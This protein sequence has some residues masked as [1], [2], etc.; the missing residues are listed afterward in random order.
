[1][2][3][4]PLVAAGILLV[5]TPTAVFGAA[6]VAC[7]LAAALT[8]HLPRAGAVAEPSTRPRAAAAGARAASSRASGWRRA[9]A[10]PG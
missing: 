8:V 6:T 10:A 5:A 1:M 9:T 3:L 4:G 7:L 2:L